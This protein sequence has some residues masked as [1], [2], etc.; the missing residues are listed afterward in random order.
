LNR[1]RASQQRSGC[2]RQLPLFHVLLQKTYE[3]P[4]SGTG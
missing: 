1:G 2:S 4:V 3:V